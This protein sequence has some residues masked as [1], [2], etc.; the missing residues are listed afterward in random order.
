MLHHSKYECGA[1]SHVSRRTL[2]RAA[3]ASGLAWL[4]PVATS[5]ARENERDS[6]GAPP[7]SLIV[8]WL[9]GGPSQ[10][11]T[12]DPHPHR[13]ISAGTRAIPTS[14]ADIQ[15]AAGLPQVAE[16]MDSITLLRS[17]VS[18]EGDHERAFYH[19]QTGFR[20]DPTLVHPSIGAVICHEL[21]APT[22]DIPRHV[23]ILPGNTPGRGGYLGESFNAFQV[24]D[25]K[26]PLQD[27]K[28]LVDE[29]R[30]RK[31][32]N[33]L[34]VID[35]QFARG[36]VASDEGVKRHTIDQA[37]K[38][39]SSEQL[40]AFD[41][42]S[43]PKADRLAF[44]DTPFGR[45]CLAAAR[46][47]QVGV[48]C[49]EVTLDGWDTHVSNHELQAGRNAILD[50]AL[51]AL[52]R[53]LKDRSLLDRT[54]VACGGEFGR[55]PTINPAGGRD[56]WPHGFSIALAGGKLPAGTVVGE[57][58]PDGGRVRFEDGIKIAD[59]HATLLDQ[60]GIQYG[61]MLDTPIGRPLRMSE[62]TPLFG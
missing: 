24:G 44:G 50:P 29:K 53:Y 27:V 48:R 16:V 12:F 41:I 40:S 37:L 25:A 8:L 4:T 28:M 33:D 55:T 61:Q 7:K 54:L 58:D 30:F 22:V 36:R 45:G 5:L 57:T 47:I 2:L 59:V 32:L 39:M 15:I 14:A 62:G 38:M 11:E 60:L 21:P 19:V 46:L 42:S 51:A 34:N 43:V 52:I 49:V 9:R 3:G 18:K 17:V 1:P 20:P 26:N 13:N 6:T 31:R 23:S 56:H 35:Q 10:L